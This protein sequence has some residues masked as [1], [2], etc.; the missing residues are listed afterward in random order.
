MARLTYDGNR[1]L[2]RAGR[3]ISSDPGKTRRRRVYEV[4]LVFWL[5]T[6]TS[7]ETR[8]TTNP[9]PNEIHSPPKRTGKINDRSIALFLP[10]PTIYDPPSS[11]FG[12]QAHLSFIHPPTCP[13]LPP[14]SHHL[15]IEKTLLP[16]TLVC[17]VE[18]N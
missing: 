14:S 16:R 17:H 3:E 2:T 8:S 18:N 4:R 9:H 15:L 11:P 1:W 7:Q 10:P 13:F 12:H 5:L 6:R